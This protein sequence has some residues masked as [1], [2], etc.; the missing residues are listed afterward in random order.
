MSQQRAPRWNGRGRPGGVKTLEGVVAS[1]A[2]AHVS[3]K[4]GGDLSFGPNRCGRSSGA[5]AAQNHRVSL[6]RSSA[7]CAME[8]TKRSAHSN[9]TAEANVVSP[10]SCRL[11]I[12]VSSTCYRHQ[13]YEAWKSGFA[14]KN[15][16]PARDYEDTVTEQLSAFASRLASDEAPN[17]DFS[18]FSPFGKRALKLMTFWAQIIVGGELTTKTVPVRPRFCTV[19]NLL[20][21]VLDNHA[22][23]GHLA[24]RATGHLRGGHPTAPQHCGHLSVVE[25]RIRLRDGRF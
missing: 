21:G 13:C 7:A 20:V 2:E 11:G 17:A 3:D 10:L 14:R 23:I 19:A 8:T 9:E 5:E 12:S 18:A 4:T 22:E 25:D 6:D 24:T 16:C 1:G 15:G